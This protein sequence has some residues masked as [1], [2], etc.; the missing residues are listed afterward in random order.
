[1]AIGCSTLATYLNGLEGSQDKLGVLIRYSPYTTGISTKPALYRK[2]D[3]DP[4]VFIIRKESLGDWRYVRGKDL[5]LI[6]ILKVS[7][8]TFLD[9]TKY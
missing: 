5:K 8:D 4:S 6:K 1:M 3:K 7:Y 2:T 9:F